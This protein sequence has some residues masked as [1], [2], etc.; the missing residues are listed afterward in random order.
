MIN[1]HFNKV[2]VMTKEDNENFESST[3][4]WICDN[5]FVESDVKVRDHCC[6]TGKYRGA[7]HV[8]CKSVESTKFLP[9]FTI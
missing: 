9:C 4:C 7:A 2:L 6:V 5:S 3:K 1:K 8:D